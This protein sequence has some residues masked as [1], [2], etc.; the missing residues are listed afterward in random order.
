M[1]N[2]RKCDRCGSYYEKIQNEPIN[3]FT[4]QGV[5]V[6]NGN[7]KNSKVFDLCDECLDKLHKFLVVEEEG[8]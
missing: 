8:L 1:A 4:W 3:E 6:I 5:R 7:I 2:V